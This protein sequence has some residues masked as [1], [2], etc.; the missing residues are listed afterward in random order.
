MSLH[1]FFD[2]SNFQRHTQDIQGDS[3]TMSKFLTID[4]IIY[5]LGPLKFT[6]L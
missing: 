1:C 5:F 6:F 4:S 3:L 2:L